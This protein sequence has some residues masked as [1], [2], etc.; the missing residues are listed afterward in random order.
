ML[1]FALFARYDKGN[2]IEDEI[3]VA[4]STQ[5]EIRNAYKILFRKHD[6]KIPLGRAKR[7]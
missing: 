6:R 4:Y 3:C 7:R 5:G 2:E 1:R